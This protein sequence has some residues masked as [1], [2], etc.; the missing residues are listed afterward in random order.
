MFTLGRKLQFIVAGHFVNIIIPY[1]SIF[2]LNVHLLNG[3]D[4]E[5][6]KVNCR[7]QWYLLDGY[8]CNDL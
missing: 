3:L 2:S 6:L 4:W 5:S 8:H 7:E 1:L